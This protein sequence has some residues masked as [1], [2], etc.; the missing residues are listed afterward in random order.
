VITIGSFSKKDSQFTGVIETLSILHEIW[1]LPTQAQDDNSPQYL[2][3]FAER[4][5]VIGR[6]WNKRADDGT[7][8]VHLVIN[9]PAM[10]A[11]L[12]CRLVKS[13]SGYDLLWDE[14]RPVS[15]DSLLAMML[16]ALH[17]ADMEIVQLLDDYSKNPP[18]DI[19]AQRVLSRIR[20]AI[21]C[22]ENYAPS[23]S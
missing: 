18:E 4:P 6:G 14:R 17:D 13:D 19:M 22:A 8:Y 2:A 12:N 5:A 10:M 1:L 7:D 11:P 16:D 21:A 9:D 3:H 20:V 15:D 23:I